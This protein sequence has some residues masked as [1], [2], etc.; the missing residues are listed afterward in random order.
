MAPDK[1]PPLHEDLLEGAAAISNFLYGRKGN[2]QRVYRAIRD[3]KLPVFRMG[4]RICARRSALM[5]FIR[6]QERHNSAR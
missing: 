2:R 3:R 5:S 1:E 6:D 4:N